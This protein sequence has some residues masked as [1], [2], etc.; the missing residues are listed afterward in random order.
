MLNWIIGILDRIFAV[1][2]AFIFS[3]APHFM[4]QYKLMLAGHVAELTY[5]VKLI[6][7]AAGE[8]GKDLNQFIQK[9]LGSLDRDFVLQGEIMNSLVVRWKELSENYVALDQVTPFARPWIFL[10]DLK[11]D[12]FKSTLASYDF[13]LVFSMET[14]IYVMIGVGIGFFSFIVLSRCVAILIRL[15]IWFFRRISATL[16]YP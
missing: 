5:Q 11:Y 9:F 15:L 1:I 3:Q 12:I 8:S 14:L 2:G 16:F 7:R 13:G 6:Q 4:Q 10:S